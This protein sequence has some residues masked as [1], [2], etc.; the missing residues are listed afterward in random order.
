MEETYPSKSKSVYLAAYAKFE[1]YMKVQKQFEPNV[2][3]D[4]TCILNY[5]HHLKV[6]LKWASTSIWSQ[7]SRINA[8]FKRRFRTSLKIY[9][10]ITDLLKLYEVGH[11]VKKS[12]VFSPQQASL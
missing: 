5:F 7:Y 10:S 6:D 1:Q 12:S 9:P 2:V 3:P 4:E 8:V 11:R